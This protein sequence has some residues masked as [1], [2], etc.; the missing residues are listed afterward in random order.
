MNERTTHQLH[1]SRT[2]HLFAGA[3]G[4]ILADLLLG[5]VCVGAVEID[6][7]CQQVL[8]A[9]QKDGFFP[10]FPI[11]SDV[12]TFKG[13]PWRGKIDILA[14]GSP[15]KG[16]S[17]ARTNNPANGRPG[18]DGGSS[19]LFYEYIRIAGEAQPDFCFWE[20]TP[21]ITTQGLEKVLSAFDALGYNTR[22]GV[23]ECASDGADHERERMFLVAY[24]DKSQRERGKLSSRAHQEHEILS[25]TNWWK[26]QPSVERVAH[27]LA[28]QSHRLVA[29]GNGQSASVAA[30]AWHVLSHGLQANP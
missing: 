7:Y 24:T 2:L 13:K 5:H 3:G 26:D 4:G 30:L 14:G 21:T 10:W 25:R 22:R 1:G 18:I 9:R 6:S 17:S 12:K 19:E 8:H 29:I 23:F 15:C 20:N 28:S 27:G 11:F 16:I